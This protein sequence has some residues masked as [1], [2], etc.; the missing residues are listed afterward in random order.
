MAHSEHRFCL[1]LRHLVAAVVALVVTLTA[2]HAIAQNNS[3]LVGRFQG[4]KPQGLRELAVK[5][6]EDEGFTVASG[7]EA[8]SGDSGEYEVVR[9]ARET[10]AVAVVLVTTGLT[11]TSW[12]STVTVRDGATGKSVGEATISGKSY[13]G[14]Q[15]AYKEKLVTELM[16][17]FEKCS[18]EESSSKPAATSNDSFSDEKEAVPEDPNE[19]PPED[20]PASNGEEADEDDE[21][22]S[23]DVDLGPDESEQRRDSLDKTEALALTLGPN[24]TLRSW[25]ISDPLT[26]AGDGPLLP[27]HDVPA[28]GF[29]AGLLVFP[30]G[31]FTQDMVR[32]IGIQVNYAMSLVGE[33]NVEN[34]TRDPNDKVRDTTLQ[35]FDAGLHIRIPVKPLTLGIIGAYGFDALVVDGS[36]TAVAVPDVQTDFIRAGLLAQLALGKA[37]SARLGLGYRYLLGFGEEAAQL[38]SVNWFPESRG[39]AFDVRLEFRQMFSSAF[40]LQLGGEINQYTIDFNVQPDHVSNASAAGRP[41]P[42]I[43]GGATDR[44]LRFDLSAVVSLGK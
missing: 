3:V 22:A 11:K 8:L 21:A 16:P 41:S 1:T 32:H 15:K 33:T 44:Y 31:F 20:E 14:L 42:P 10:H 28:V 38:Q 7:G 39:T 23:E 19:L 30:A 13:K 26:N 12:R 17:L 29:R 6:L 18:A 25:A 2:Q 27:A 24:L 4:S 37:S 40:G 34:V 43:A 36:K 9:T 35:S 5:L